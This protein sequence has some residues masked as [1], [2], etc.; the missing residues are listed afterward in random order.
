MHFSFKII[1]EIIPHTLKLHFTGEF[2]LQW[3]GLEIVVEITSDPLNNEI[4]DEFISLGSQFDFI[5]DNSTCI[6]V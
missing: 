2:T 4:N 5:G 3:R 1:R 6:K